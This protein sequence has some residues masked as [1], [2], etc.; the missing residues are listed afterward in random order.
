M[1]RTKENMLA[2]SL[3]YQ[4]ADNHNVSGKTLRQTMT[5]I[6]LI[7]TDQEFYNIVRNVESTGFRLPT[8]SRYSYLEEMN[9]DM[10]NI[11]FW[12]KQRRV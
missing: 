7:K 5:E 8:L 3:L 2:F 10:K 1:K 4:W 9:T 11:F 12:I 6:G